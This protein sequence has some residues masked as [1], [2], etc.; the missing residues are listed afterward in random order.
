MTLFVVLAALFAAVA[1]AFVLPPLL[2]GAKPAAGVVRDEMNSLIYREQLAELRA[3][4]ERGAMTENQFQRAMRDLE[5]RIVAE[6]GATAA[7]AP[8]VSHALAAVVVALAIPLIAGLGYWRLG[9]PDA[10]QP[11]ATEA[12]AQP[13]AAQVE[14]MVEK[15]WSRL[16][17]S[18]E[19]AEGWALLGRSLASL[20][21]HERA[22]Q[23][24]LQAAQ[25]LPNDANVL[26]DYADA[27]S[28]TRGRRLEG[29]PMLLVRRALAADPQHLKALALAGAGEYQAGNHAA[30][31]VH[32]K[33]VLAVLPPD[34]EFAR[35]LQ[36]GLAETE[37]LAAAGKAPAKQLAGLQGTVSLDPK[38]AAA[39]APGDTV[40]VIA[41]PA[42]GGRMP[43]AVART[44]VSALPYQF[45]L[46][47]SMAMAPGVKLSEQA[48]V[49]VVARISKSGQPISQKGDL[50]GA[51]DPVAPTASGLNVVISKTIE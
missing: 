6:A 30:A 10:L 46:V 36:A 16:K 9:A 22:A 5:R 35:Q 39:A 45:T 7:A 43:L 44:T 37:Q 41:R 47:D 2:R 51:S 18:P 49:V 28:L 50:E 14:A 31:A 23:A 1:L 21:Q 15:L 8:H 26:A 20:G 3:E 33:K 34:S 42:D 29:E 11:G 4:R 24:H 32:W 27:L 48:K 19:D 12:M 40:F 38:L 17:Q 13:D 25:R